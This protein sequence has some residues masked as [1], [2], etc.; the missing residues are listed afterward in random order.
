[1]PVF[2]LQDLI[3]LIIS[4]F[5]ILP[6]VVFLRELGYV[7]TSAV[8]GV[9]NP[10]LTVGSGPRVFKFGIFDF[11][12]YYHLYSW[13]SYDD[14]KRKGKFIYVLIYAGPILINLIP[15]LILNALLANGII[16]KYETFWSRFLFYQFYYVLFD[17]VPMK[18]VN[19]MPNNGMII[20][21]MLRY[22]KRVDY[23]TDPFI[24][25]TTQVEEEYREEMEEIEEQMEEME[26][27]EEEMKENGEVKEVRRDG[28][29]DEEDRKERKLGGLDN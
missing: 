16:V 24:P 5:I 27:A 10:R 26:E 14:L 3:S 22:G 29:E 13:F 20:Y 21:E 15:A 2:G 23:N 17:V 19:G 7:I 6:V 4:A 9:V 25:S 28:N 18:T 11:R 12:R 1:M 8:F